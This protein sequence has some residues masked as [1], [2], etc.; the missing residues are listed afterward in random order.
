MLKTINEVF[1][2]RD[3]VRC[4]SVT[5]KDDGAINIVAKNLKKLGF[6]CQFMEFKEKELHKLKIYM[7]KLGKILQ[8]FVLQDTLTLFRLGI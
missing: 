5:P 4:K 1:L 7:Q 8:I 2:A 6:K 3:L